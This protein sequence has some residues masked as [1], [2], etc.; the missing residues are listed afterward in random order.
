MPKNA[1]AMPTAAQIALAVSRANMSGPCFPLP[2]GYTSAALNREI[3]APR[4]ASAPQE[5]RA[6][7]GADA[8]RDQQ[9]LDGLGA[10]TLPQFLGILIG[11]VLG[12][13]LVFQCGGLGLP[14][15][16]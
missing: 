14:R 6:Q 9:G 7:K 10:D 4:G 11:P 15:G 12:L 1:M 13:F 5:N 8:A 2:S 16:F 3:N